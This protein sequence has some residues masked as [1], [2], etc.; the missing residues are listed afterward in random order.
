MNKYI[1]ADKLKAEIEKMFNENGALG[2]MAE[3][4]AHRA[5]EDY[6]ILSL[7]ETMQE[8]EAEIEKE[9]EVSPSM[10]SNFGPCTFNLSVTLSQEEMAKMN[11]VPFLSRTVR[12]KIIDDEQE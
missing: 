4:F 10:V 7:I 1:N 2:Q 3:R 9:A 6:N 11:I 5:A 8:E 12:V